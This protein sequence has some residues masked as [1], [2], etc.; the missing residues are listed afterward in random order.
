MNRTEWEK[1]LTEFRTYLETDRALATITIRNYLIDIEHL[2]PFMLKNKLLKFSDFDRSLIRKYLS[3]LIELGYVRRSVTRKLS[4]VRT[5]LSWLIKL[6]V[7]MHDPIPPKGIIKSEKRLPDYLT[8]SEVVKLLDTP[9][10]STNLGVRDKAILELLYSSGLRV[11]EIVNI[12]M[13]DLNLNTLEL[14]VFGKGSKQ[15]MVIIGRVA[16]KY[17]NIY[18]RKS[19]PKLLS[20]ELNNAL[21]LNRYGNRLSQRSIQS[22]IRIY[23]VKAGLRDGGH[24]HT[25]RHSFAT[26]ML[27]GGADLRVVQELLGHSNPATTQIYTHISD[28][29][30]ESV[31]NYAHP[32][33]KQNI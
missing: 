15:R 33:S 24:V 9:D 13:E 4:T 27:E 22:K 1:T 29:E 30:A 2:Y 14:K 31:Y 25:L 32:R 28:I 20:Q 7:L 18:I 8:Q 26:H 11:S 19:R 3:W 12:N 5:F 10:T 17:I 21:F 16:S 6:G 23:S